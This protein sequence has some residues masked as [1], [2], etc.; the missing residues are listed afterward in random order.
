MRLWDPFA[1]RELSALLKDP[2]FRGRGVPHGDG[3]PVLLIPGFLAGDWTLRMMHAWLGRV[4][5]R[6]YLSG[7]VLNVQH[8]ERML[9]GLRR[10]VGAI[11]KETGSRVSLIGHSRGGL[12]AKVYSQRK[13]EGLRPQARSH[14]PDDI[15]LHQGGRRREFSILPPPRH[16]GDAGVGNPQRPGGQPR[17]L[18]F[19]GKASRATGPSVIAIAVGMALAAAAFHGTW[20]VLVKVSGDPIATFRRATLVAGLIATIVFVP[21]WL[22]L[23]RPTLDPAAAG[24]CVVS[25]LLETLYLWLLSAA[26]RRGELSAVYPIARGSAPLLSVL[27]GLAVLGERLAT[28]QLIGVGLLLLGILAVTLSQASGRA[29]VPA[30]LTGVAIAAYT[31]VDRVGVRL[32][33]PWMY[34]WLLFTLMAIELPIT[35]WVAARLGLYRAPDPYSGPTWRQAV[36]I[37]VFFLAGYV[38][39]LFALSFAPL[40]IVA[41]VRETAVVAV[42][43]W[44]VWRLRERSRTTIKLSGAL[45]TLAGVALLAS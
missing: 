38:L 45:A 3:R 13:P 30:L 28:L 23:G 36:I 33:E 19:G 44:G 12:L 26:F 31:T 18:P 11:Q 22:L 2:V 37:G 15:D 7:I 35:L 16:P 14:R 10:K 1:I 40:A 29:T 17:G 34:G 43:V 39:V 4:G 21:A 42:A 6:A 8:S 5:Y 9:A 24:F 25:S 32:T 41:P 27:V 20:N